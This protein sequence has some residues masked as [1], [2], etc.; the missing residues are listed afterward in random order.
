M[1]HKLLERELTP[2]WFALFG[3]LYLLGVYPPIDI[4]IHDGQRMFACVVLAAALIRYGGLVEG[5]QLTWLIA[6]F[7]LMGL[8]TA[9]QASWTGVAV[10]LSWIGLLAWGW[11]VYHLSLSHPG[12]L[13]KLWPAAAVFMAIAY[14]VR[15][16]AAIVAAVPQHEV[17]LSEVFLG[18]GNLRH[19]AQLI[20]LLLPLLAVA[21]LPLNRSPRLAE[22]FRAL[23]M[24]ALLSWCVLLWLNGSAGALYGSLIGLGSAVAIAG[25]ERSRCLV[26]TMLL[27]GGVAVLVILGLNRLVPLLGE[28]AQSARV[29]E[30][31]RLEIWAATLRALA[32]QPLLGWGPD[33]FPV[34][35]DVKP[36]HPHNA[37]LAF[38][39][40]FGVL[41][42]LL[43][44]V[45]MW[46]WFSPFR[47][48]RQ[49][50]AMSI[51]EAHWPVA[52]TA[53]AFG[54]L[55]HAQVSGVTVM[56]LAQL[57]LALSLGLLLASVTGEAPKL[58]YSRTS[59]VLGG[60]LAVSLIV[61][62]LASAWLSPCG[63]FASSQ[64]VCSQAAS[65]WSRNPIPQDRE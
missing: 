13:Q 28:I 56:P 65:F 23:A 62:T 14:A 15:V 45:V 33:R 5:L 41:A 54:G 60:I 35:V 11:H 18:F 4:P 17:L 20:P 24:L 27:A 55:A 3:L 2:I 43:L 9:W 8:A 63:P 19:F 1:A 31:G 29:Q 53:A 36:G 38:A 40:D 58:S 32:E 57:L 49:I 61:A 7:G 37:V 39:M 47:L 51:A 48:A 6:L 59:R 12:V 44:V 26:T 25:W 30:S 46:R 50:R 64:A 42:L 21:C 10:L 34:V 22:L 52:L 16:G